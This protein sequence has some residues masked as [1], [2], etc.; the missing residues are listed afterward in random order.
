MHFDDTIPAA[1]FDPLK[2]LGSELIDA[3]NVKKRVTG[4][5]NHAL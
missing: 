3:H 4:K 5:L 1:A 2:G